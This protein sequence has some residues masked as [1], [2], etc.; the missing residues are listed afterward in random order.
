[1]KVPENNPGISFWDLAMDPTRQR[2]NSNDVHKI[3]P[4]NIQTNVALSQSYKA[5]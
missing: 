1:M 2:R 3:E 5:R 4:F